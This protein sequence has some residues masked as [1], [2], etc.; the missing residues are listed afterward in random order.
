MTRV[1]VSGCVAF[2]SMLL[3]ASAPFAQEPLPLD[4]FT[5]SDELGTMKISP[6]G[7]FLAM[8]TGQ[9]GAEFLTFVSLKDG[10][11]TLKTPAGKE[12]ILAL[13]TLSAE[14]QARARELAVEKPK[15]PK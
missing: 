10:K 8:T 3:F 12:H 1:W 11:V 2:L 14:S 4:V 7:E 9:H 13:D 6:D 15:A 5:R